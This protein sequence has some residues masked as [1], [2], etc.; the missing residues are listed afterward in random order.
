MMHIEYDPKYHHL[1]LLAND[2]EQDVIHHFDE[3]PIY[4]L[5]IKTQQGQLRALRFD[6]NQPEF[7]PL[8]KAFSCFTNPIR[9]LRDHFGLSQQQLAD[10]VGLTKAR[11]SQLENSAK[12]SPAQ[13]DR[14]H[15]AI[16]AHAVS[17]SDLSSWIIGV[18]KNGQPVYGSPRPTY[19]IEHGK[20]LYFE[21]GT[22]IAND[23]AID[24]FKVPVEG[25]DNAA[26]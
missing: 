9:R 19:T 25:M 22:V 4:G 15:K 26:A 20:S 17:H 5:Y 13:V 23:D 11:I 16:I 2:D 21:D 7:K 12:V 3:T 14:I 18:L 1:V 8:L 10:L 24:W 6:L